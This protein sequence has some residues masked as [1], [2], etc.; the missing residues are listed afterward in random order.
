MN[1]YITMKTS[2]LL[3]ALTGSA[4]GAPPV[5]VRS[6]SL[7]SRQLGDIGWN[8]YMGSWHGEGVV[9]CSL[10]SFDHLSHHAAEI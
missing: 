3:L 6:D 8:I 1:F 7:D 9:C 10:S 2:A 5:A 4:L